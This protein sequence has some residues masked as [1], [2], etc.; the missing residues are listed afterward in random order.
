MSTVG[1]I[2]WE[3]DREP[4]EWRGDAVLSKVV[5]EG[6]TKQWCLVKV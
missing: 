5:E 4:L 6:I 1:K 2:D 3:G